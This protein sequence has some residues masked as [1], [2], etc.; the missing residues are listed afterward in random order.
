MELLSI[1]PIVSGLFFAGLVIAILLFKEFRK[2]LKD[3]TVRKA[4]ALH[5]NILRY[6][7]YDKL[8][9]QILK[10]ELDHNQN[11]KED[12]MDV[13]IKDPKGWQKFCLSKEEEY[14]PQFPIGMHIKIFIPEESE[15]V[16]GVVTNNKKYSFGWWKYDV[17]MSEPVGINNSFPDRY[18][19]LSE[20]QLSGIVDGKITGSFIHIIRR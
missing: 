20:N 11:V 4:S 1:S 17:S 15:Y 14:T 18:L 9:N 10:G 7:R 8:F 5:M 3:P 19:H 6:N 16:E 12:F 2:S 13:M